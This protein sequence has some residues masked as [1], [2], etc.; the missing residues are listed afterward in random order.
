MRVGVVY[1]EA[2]VRCNVYAIILYYYNIIRYYATIYII[3][4]VM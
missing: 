3:S 4:M 2:W 1:I